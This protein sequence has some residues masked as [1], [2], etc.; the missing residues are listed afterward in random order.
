MISNRLLFQHSIGWWLLF[1]TTEN[2]DW[3]LWITVIGGCLKTVVISTLFGCWFGT[4]V[5][6]CWE[7]WWLVI[8]YLGIVVISIWL[9]FQHSIGSWLVVGWEQWWL[10]GALFISGCWEQWWIVIFGWEQWWI[11]IWLLVGSS[12]DCWLLGTVV[13]S[14]YWLWAVI[15]CLGSSGDLWWLLETVVISD[16]LDSCD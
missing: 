12:G 14:D 11:V 10:L 16:C 2:S 9:L 8:S 4:V 13:I 7:L 15:D 1:E 5:I 6:V 3:P